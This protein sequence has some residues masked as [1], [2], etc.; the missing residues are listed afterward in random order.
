MSP[1][2]G[3]DIPCL[4]GDP[5]YDVR[6]PWRQG[7]LTPGLTCVFRMRNEAH[8]LPWVLPGML[9]AVQHV[10]VVDNLSD[11]GTAEEARRIA[12]ELGAG[13]RLTVL[14]YPFQ[15][16]RAG[17]EH[18]ATPP[19]SVH[20]LTHFYNWSL[21]QVRTSYSM[22]WDGDMVLTREGV[23]LLADLSWQLEE[24]GAVVALPR[25]PLTVE[26]DSVAWLDLGYRF[27]EPWV[28][29]M[30]PEFTFVKA[31]EW[32]VREFPD[33]SD[34]IIAPEGMVVELKWLDRD[35]F[36][37][38][39]S[40]TDFDSSRAPRKRREWE[41]FTALSEGRGEELLGLHRIEAPP[42]VHVIDH[43]T[44]TWLP[45]APRPLVRR[46]GRFNV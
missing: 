11:D 25:H 21:S 15:V 8:N 36:T 35:E 30:G 7:R 38:W 23:A 5:T 4:E 32:E 46:R 10:I 19:D 6:W 40:T 2:R 9:E 31:F 44:R 45:Q 37:H 27:L 22:K 33:D 16:A 3:A 13:E 34:R 24:S 20:S 42:G 12:D 26:S 43:V 39:T 14:D 28:Y 18:L 1:V 17:T 29:P 41:V